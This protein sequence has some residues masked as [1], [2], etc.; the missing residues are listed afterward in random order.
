MSKDI[1][2]WVPAAGA[3]VTIVDA[4][5]VTQ[6]VITDENGYYTFENVAVN[7]NTVIT[8]TATVDGKTIVLK[9][10]IPQA[11]AADEDYDAGTMD[12][13]TTALALVVEELIDEGVEPVDINLAEVQASETFTDLVEQVSEVLEEQGNVTEDPDVIDGAGDTADEILNPPAPPSPPSGPSTV[14]VTSVSIEQEDQI[15]IVG[16]TLDL[17]A[18]FEPANATNKNVNWT[19]DKNDVATVSVEGSVT[20]VAEGVAVITVTTEDGEKF[21]TITITVS[22]IYNQTQ[23]T[24]HNT[25]QDAIDTATAGDTILVGAGEFVEE[26]QI[27]IDKDLSIIG[28]DKEATIIKPNQNTGDR[29]SGDDRGWFLVSENVE[30]NLSNVTLNGEGYNICVAVCSKGSGTIEDNIFKNIKHS[31]YFGWGIDLYQSGTGLTIKNNQFINIERLGVHVKFGDGTKIIS[32]TFTGNGDGDYLQYGI[33]VN[34]APQNVEIDGN[35]FTY[36]GESGTDWGSGAIFVDDAFQTGIPSVT[37]TNNTITNNEVGI[38]HGSNRTWPEVLDVEISDNHFA[39]NGRHVVDDSNDTTSS[40]VLN[41]EDV[42]DNNSFAAQVLID[43]ETKSIID[44]ANAKVLNVNKSKVYSTIQAAVDDANDDDVIEIATGTY[45]ENVSISDKSL[46]ISGVSGPVLS[47]GIIAKTT[48]AG[49]N[50]DVS[51]IDFQTSG[52]EVDGYDEVLIKENT[53]TDINTWTTE[54]YD[55]GSADA[56]YVHGSETGTVNIEGNTIT[57]VSSNATNIGDGMGI[58]VLDLDYITISGNNISDTWH[59]SI[60]IYQGIANS[61]TITDNTL[62]NWDSNMDDGGM[63]SGCEGGRALRID[64]AGGATITV[65]ANTFAPNANPDRV[66]PDYVKITNCNNDIATLRSAIEDN[67]DWPD[68]VVYDTVLTVN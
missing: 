35:T 15:L 46:S 53:F 55:D 8:A 11:V 47:G 41:L 42:I 27:V 24:S 12:P 21:D 18:T 38:Y 20:A 67:N 52:L 4:N 50:I 63:T 45:T 30:F 7:S 10:V 37:I 34:R 13:E 5:G 54:Q 61:V 43:S 1:S 31:P 19:S 48:I 57:T 16:N 9:G 29:N 56:I 49:K 66:D 32:N 22:K 36:Y 3:E 62:G 51:A 40:Y 44:A 25:I 2:G 26:G 68:G 39:D 28:V 33:E 59:N 65:T 23:K 60:N 6:T 58:T 64:L 17:T 14:S